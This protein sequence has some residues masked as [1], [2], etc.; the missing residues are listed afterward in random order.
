[1]L[2]DL[3]RDDLADMREEGLTPSDEDII[4]LH[5][6]AS[7]IS[8]GPE[9]T[10]YNAPRFA[11]AGGVVFWEPTVAAAK[12]CTFARQFAEDESV[13]VWTTAYACANGR[14]RGAFDNLYDPAAIEKALGEFMGGMAATFAEVERAV[15]YA[16]Y[17]SEHVDAEPTPLE[18]ARD[19]KLTPT[20]RERRNYAA[21]EEVLSRAATATGLTY[22][23][24]VLHTTSR[25]V[26][27]LYAAHVEAGEKMTPSSAAAHAAYLATKHAIIDRLRAERAASTPS[28][29]L[30]QRPDAAR[31]SE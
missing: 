15:H 22:E 19:A 30:T 2:S 8:D 16:I 10:A 6:L 27:Y 21:M 4:R 29:N 1:M 14:K 11:V 17:G 26:G 13:E 24:L 5:A 31:E 18:K 3:A 20:E 28:D 12:W 25:L 7:R 9:T 23:D